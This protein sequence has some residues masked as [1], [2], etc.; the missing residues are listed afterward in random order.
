MAGKL[1]SFL[2]I[3]LSDELRSEL[4]DLRTRLALP[5]FDVR[6]V[7]TKNIHLTL[8]FLGEIQEEEIPGISRAASNAAAG[9]EPFRIELLGV[10]AFP[11]TTSPRVIWAG[12]EH[13]GPMIRLER[14]L[15]RE[16]RQAE[17]PPPDKPFRPHLTLGRVKSSRGKKE[18]KKLLLR[19]QRVPIGS[20]EVEQFALIKSELRPSGPIYT[21]L[22]SFKLRP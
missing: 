14:N 16:L 22:E 11:S 10:D 19:N 17:Y 20:M 9:L 5:Q 3:E 4:D 13:S 6:W 2:A 1:R 12:I 21:I 7:A 8:R 18:L 15:T